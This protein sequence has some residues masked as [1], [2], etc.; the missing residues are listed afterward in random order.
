VLIGL[1]AL[2]KLLPALFLLWLVLKRAWAALA[3]ALITILVAAVVP[4]LITFG[5]QQT[6]AYH[7][8]WWQH[9]VRGAPAQGLVDAALREHFTDHRNQSIPAVLAR[10]T[11]A[12]HPHPAPRQ[13][14]D[15]SPPAIR[16]I[17]VGAA[18]VILAALVFRA[19]KPLAALTEATVR[20]ET[21]LL[22]LAML[23]LPPLL[24]TYY[25]LWAA[26]AVLLL[27]HAMLSVDAARR[28]RICGR[29]GTIAWLV[30]ML[31]WAW[32][33]ARDYGVHLWMLL[34][35]GVLLAVSTDQGAPVRR[36]IATEPE[37]PGTPS[38]A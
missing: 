28:L 14:A 24:R 6:V 29:I 8:Q 36:S 2:L 5:P 3:A 21:A 35:L 20:S 32:P 30:G 11:W 12:D 25:L 22:L 18:C 9:N 7:Q 34:I 13:L 4:C 17:S 26:P 27:V 1:A 16:A 15:L 33:A 38:P 10:L 23:V 19:R 31:A 37:F